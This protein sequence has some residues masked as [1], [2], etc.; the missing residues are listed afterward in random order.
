MYAPRHTLLLE[1]YTAFARCG[2]LHFWTRRLDDARLPLARSRVPRA[3][4]ARNSADGAG[5]RSLAFLAARIASRC[6]RRSKK[7]GAIS[8]D[9]CTR[10]ESADNI[11][12]PVW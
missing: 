5:V 12:A 1:G 3:V 6:C 10:R 7:I 4:E 8:L 11:V 9:E 2:S